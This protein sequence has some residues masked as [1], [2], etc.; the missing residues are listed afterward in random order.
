MSEYLLRID[1]ENYKWIKAMAKS[2]NKSIR[3]MLNEWIEQAVK[4]YRNEVKRKLEEIFEDWSPVKE[5]FDTLPVGAQDDAVTIEAVGWTPDV[6]LDI[7]FVPIK[8]EH[9]YYKEEIENIRATLRFYWKERFY[10]Q[11]GD[12]L[13]V[14]I[15]L[16]DE[17]WK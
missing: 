8:D 6:G 9:K 14:I 7:T 17:L 5:Q 13:D 16:L 3:Q 4:E 10:V 12:K 15:S 1:D 2:Q 11:F